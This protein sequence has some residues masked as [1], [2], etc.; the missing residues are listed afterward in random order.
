[1]IPEILSELAGHIGQIY[2]LTGPV[3]QDMD[4]VVREFSTA[5]GRTI[6]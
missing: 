2:H 1:M 4:A 3:S 6:T 5:V